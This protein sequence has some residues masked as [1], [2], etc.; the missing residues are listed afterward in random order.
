M[1]NRKYLE[2]TLVGRARRD[3]FRSLY[4]YKYLR[5]SLDVI[6]PSPMSRGKNRSENTPEGMRCLKCNIHGI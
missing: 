3:I 5:A 2:G 4:I 1:D 6:A